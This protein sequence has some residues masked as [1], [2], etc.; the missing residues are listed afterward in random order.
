MRSQETKCAAFD[1]A[2]LVGK[3]WTIA[4][5]QE[6]ENNGGKGFNFLVKR[7]G[8][9]PKVLSTRLK[10]LE[11]QG[12][13]I[14]KT[15]ETSARSS[16]ALT[17]KGRELNQVVTALRAWNEKHNPDHAGCTTRNCVECPRFLKTY[18]N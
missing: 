7:V 15:S 2:S 17:Q 9:T 12:L 6:I 16:Y 11:Q 1:A 14:K 3:K 18:A 8:K 4:L 13:V 5:M 10:Q